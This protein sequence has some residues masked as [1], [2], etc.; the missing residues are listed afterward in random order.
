MADDMGLGKTIQIITHI[1]RLKEKGENGPHL[2]VVPKSLIE[3]WVREITIFLKTPFLHITTM[4][5]AL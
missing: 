3:N 4:A 2:I 1:L 5:E